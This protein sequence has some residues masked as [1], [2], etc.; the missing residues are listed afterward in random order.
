MWPGTLP[1]SGTC[2]P[3]L[4][5]FVDHRRYVH[6]LLEAVDVRERVT[7]VFHDWGSVL[8]F[9][10]ANDFDPS[11]AGKLAIPTFT[12]VG[13]GRSGS[14]IRATAAGLRRWQLEVPCPAA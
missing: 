9:D 10:Q 8:G 6:A 2:G 3:G 7:F 5:R 14:D 4:Y 11:T 12:L 13:D 1:S